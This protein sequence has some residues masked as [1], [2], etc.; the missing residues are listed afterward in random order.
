M[1]VGARLFCFAWTDEPL[2]CLALLID[3]AKILQLS[4]PECAVPGWDCVRKL[5]KYLDKMMTE[6]LQKFLLAAGT[7]VREEGRS[8]Q[9]TRVMDAADKML[10]EYRAASP[11]CSSD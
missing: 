6:G 7:T 2:M 3:S 11:W 10:Q 1:T 8:Q 5:L 4:G 9:T